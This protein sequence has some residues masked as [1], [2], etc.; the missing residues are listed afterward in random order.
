MSDVLRIKRRLAGGASG[1]PASLKNAELAFN[2]QDNTLYYG[3]GDS[4]G[5]A[6]SIIAVGGPGA[7]QPLD[8]DLTAFAALTG[9]NTI[10]YRSGADTWSPVTMG[11]N[12]TFSGGVLNSTGGA[13]VA[14]ISPPQGRLTLQSLTPVMT[15]TQAAKTT[16]YYTPQVGNLIPLYDGTNFV[17]T[18]IGTEI[19]ALTTDATKSP[20]AIGASKVN[21]WF[22]WNDAG[23]IR[24]GH[25]PDWTND[26]TRSAG[27]ALV[28]VNGIRLNS[29]AIT[30]GPAAQ[31]GTYVGTT[32]SNASS[33]FDWI[34]GATNT[35][36]F[37]G[38]GI[39]IIAW[40]F[41]CPL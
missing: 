41:L 35:A 39:A 30:N 29:A 7:F 32:R 22:V 4:G 19:S 1:A 28:M 14:I 40:T 38:F 3:K 6:T 11:G 5:N 18:S 37:L 17:M 23:T 31:R 27:T 33:Q 20:A 25:G 16:I 2:E 21:D 13:G 10:Y 12:M 26:T 24:L 9:T 8:A 34:V 36:A 15:I